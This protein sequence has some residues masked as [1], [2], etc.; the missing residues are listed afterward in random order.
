MAPT[1]TT[2]QEE[3]KKPPYSFRAGALLCVIRPGGIR[4]EPDMYKKEWARFRTYSTLQLPPGV[5]K[6]MFLRKGVVVLCL[7]NTL[8]ENLGIR[9]MR[10]MYQERFYTYIGY[11]LPEEV[12][13]PVI[14]D[15][16][17]TTFSTEEND[18]E[19]ND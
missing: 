15:E 13:S 10:F 18:P 3:T 14:E 8:N 9:V 6:A 7:E 4:C 5:K 11:Y 19:D 1:T 12:F 17:S 16:T 2:P